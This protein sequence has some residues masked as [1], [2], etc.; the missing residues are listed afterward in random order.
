MSAPISAA[1]LEM[2]P[3]FSATAVLANVS[4]EAYV[5][6][7]PGAWSWF[8]LAE[9]CRCPGGGA[10]SSCFSLRWGEHPSSPWWGE[11]PTS[12]CH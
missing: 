9:T 3:Q 12:P 5:P 8:G 1:M 4:R 6:W 7:G 10:D 2:R 11:G